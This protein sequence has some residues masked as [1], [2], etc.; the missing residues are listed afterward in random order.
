MSGVEHYKWLQDQ[1]AQQG[2]LDFLNV[3]N[4]GF[5]VE[6]LIAKEIQARLSKTEMVSSTNPETL[7]KASINEKL[8]SIGEFENSTYKRTSTDEKER[9]QTNNASFFESKEQE[10]ADRAAGILE[11]NNARRAKEEAEKVRVAK[12][13]EAAEAAAEA[14]AEILADE[15]RWAEEEAERAR[16][17]DAITPKKENEFANSKLASLARLSEEAKTADLAARELEDKKR[18]GLEQ[19]E[20]TFSENLK[21][22]ELELQELKDNGTT[23]YHQFEAKAEVEKAKRNL[24]RI[25]E[26]LRTHD[27]EVNTRRGAVES[28]QNARN[29]TIKEEEE[30]AETLRLE[31]NAIIAAEDARIKAE[32]DAE[33]AAEAAEVAAEDALRAAEAAA[34]VAE[35][36]AEAAAEKAEQEVEEA[37]E[38][39]EK[40]AERIAALPTFTDVTNTKLGA[41]EARIKAATSGTYDMITKGAQSAMDRVRDVSTADYSA[42]VQQL[43]SSSIAGFNGR[44]TAETSES[45]NSAS[46]KVSL[47]LNLNNQSVTGTFDD[48]SELD[49]ILNALKLQQRVI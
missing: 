42:P 41:L 25:T 35:E 18:E 21:I 24:S 23:E 4:I 5:D 6:D 29:E 19:Q 40:E 3:D 39:A 22:K 13:E 37:A 45:F 34:E 7:L 12:E 16:Q 8:S 11:E 20:K 48:S 10:K 26:K 31:Q 44:S 43:N 15:A 46:K 30:D 38:A 32:D 47:T 17:I 14:K 2:K 9:I 27:N 49:N 28:E 36:A 1:Q 33:A